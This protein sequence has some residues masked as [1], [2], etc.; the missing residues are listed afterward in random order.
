[1]SNTP[2]PPA[3][4][5][6]KE[7]E[8]SSSDAQL[9]SLVERISR[10]EEENTTLKKDN[11]ALQ[12]QYASREDELRNDFE[13]VQQHFEKYR[14]GMAIKMQAKDERIKE[15]EAQIKQMHASLEAKATTAAPLA[16]DGESDHEAAERK[17]DYEAYLKDKLTDLQQRAVAQLREYKELLRKHAIYASSSGS[18]DDDDEESRR[19]PLALERFIDDLQGQIVQLTKSKDAAVANMQ[20]KIN[21]LQAENQ[22]LSTMVEYAKKTNAST[23]V[24][25][26]K[27]YIEELEERLQ[28]ANEE[29][30]HRLRDENILLKAEN[31]SH[32]QEIATLNSKLKTMTAFDAKQS[33]MPSHPLFLNNFIANLDSLLAESNIDSNELQ[34]RYI[35]TADKLTRPIFTKIIELKSYKTPAAVDGMHGGMMATTNGNSPAAA[36]NGSGN[37]TPLS[38][39]ALAGDA[40]TPP[41]H[42]FAKAGGGDAA[43]ADAMRKKFGVHRNF[44]Y[45]QDAAD[46]AETLENIIFEQEDYI[47]KLERTLDGIVHS[48]KIMSK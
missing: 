43:T 42:A 20:R 11:V 25:K 22:N 4:S 8:K 17:S 7:S 48:Q 21:D 10:L 47:Q 15:I 14:D 3:A 45:E 27:D 26:C 13:E 40:H 12:T 38:T 30:F 32:T 2:P 6:A 36:S 1:M 39:V 35:Q 5:T 9:V 46:A 23:D 28:K 33:T 18:S 41:L 29:E 16:V 19:G 31:A 24:V 37:M 44:T 34:D